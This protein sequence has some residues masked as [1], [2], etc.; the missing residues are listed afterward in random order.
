ML[1][2][3][4]NRKLEKEGA[5]RGLNPEPCPLGNDCVT[6]QPMHIL[7][8]VPSLLI[9]QMGEEFRFMNIFIAISLLGARPSD[10]QS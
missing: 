8:G 2:R 4:S 9:S 7:L 10:L 6:N 5:R 3:Q 1:T